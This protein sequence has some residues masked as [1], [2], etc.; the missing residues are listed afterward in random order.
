MEV[1]GG[2]GGGGW[3]GGE[4]RAP[5]S[6]R[7]LETPSGID[8]MIVDPPR[9]M[10]VFSSLCDVQIMHSACLHSMKDP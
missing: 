7:M 10:Q 5:T 8:L 4:G 2:G 3:R 6:W 9:T 1:G